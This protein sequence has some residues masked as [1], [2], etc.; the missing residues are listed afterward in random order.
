MLQHNWGT[1]K[2]RKFLMLFAVCMLFTGCV[3]TKKT[4]IDYSASC[5]KMTPENSVVI[6]LATVGDASM[7]IGQI[8]EAY[9]ADFQELRSKGV[10][11]YF[12]TKPLVPGSTYRIAYE[13]SANGKSKVYSDLNTPYNVINVP[14]E[15]GLYYLG[16]FAGLNT[17]GTS[18]VDYKLISNLWLVGWSAESGEKKCLALASKLYAGTSWQDVITARQEKIANEK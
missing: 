10:G 11:T 7:G 14:K 15:P 9:P 13:T 1:F 6:M 2:M 12:V 4:A 18:L 3:S 16:L 5:E 8:D 17:S